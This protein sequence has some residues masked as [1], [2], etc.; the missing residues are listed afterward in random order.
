MRAGEFVT[1]PDEKSVADLSAAGVVPERRLLALDALSNLTLE[2]AR[3][4]DVNRLLEVALLTLSGQFAVSSAFAIIRSPSEDGASS[5]IRATGRFVDHPLLD[6][7]AGAL[8]ELHVLLEDG[9]PRTIDEL[10]AAGLDPDFVSTLRIATVKAVVPLVHNHRLIGLLGLGPRVG[11][12]AY[13]PSDLTLLSTIASTLTPL[14]INSV[15]FGDIARLKAW[16][17][18][19]LNSVR[20]AV[21]VFDHEYG[22]KMVNQTGRALLDAAYAGTGLQVPQVGDKL[23]KVFAPQV[24]PTWVTRLGMAQSD[25]GRDTL[26]RLRCMLGGEERILSGRLTQVTGRTGMDFDLIVTL[27]D[28]TGQTDQEQRL[29]DLQKLAEQGMMA[30]S[31]AHELNNFLALIAAGA[32]IA[33]R[34]LKAQDLERVAKS[35]EKVR[36]TA[37]SM[38]RFTLGL[39]DH[40]R[41]RHEIR[42]GQLNTLIAHILSFVAVQKRFKGIVLECDLEASLPTFRF[43]PDRLSQVILNLLN[44]AADAIR[45]EGRDS[46]RIFLRTRSDRGWIVLTVEDDGPGVPPALQDVLLKV[47]HTTKE[48][49]HGFGL[50][51]CARII[52]EH[53]GSITLSSQNTGGACFEIRLPERGQDASA[54]GPPE[55]TSRPSNPA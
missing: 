24:F 12:R 7:M 25:T 5:R 46:G 50:V 36:E 39:A 8:G 17:L 19:I 38:G 44:N 28:V 47:R 16:Y 4:P 55:A 40:S 2:F 21:F 42:E 9:S 15:L 23:V 49:G 51:T 37:T 18:D 31:I 33:G 34:A 10:Q 20:Q 53:G 48:T 3:H 30:A 52:S 6:L 1:G 43:D 54:P 14:L 35:L 45:G 22:L 26:D 29:F 41:E 27:E 13:G 11:A 32:E